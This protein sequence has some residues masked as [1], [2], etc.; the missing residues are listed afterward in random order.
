MVAIHKGKEAFVHPRGVDDFQMWSVSV[1]KE[2]EGEQRGD[3]AVRRVLG[4]LGDLKMFG[5]W[6]VGRK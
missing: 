5:D 6:K 3:D 2:Q 1:L 4:D